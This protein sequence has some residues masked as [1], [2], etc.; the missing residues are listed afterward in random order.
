MKYK[1]F[2]VVFTAILLLSTVVYAAG[3]FDRGDQHIRGNWTFHNDALFVDDTYA[4]F[5]LPLGSFN[6]SGSPIQ[7]DG[8]SAPGMA[9]H[10]S[11]PKIVW[12]TTEV[13]PIQASFW[14]PPLKGKNATLAFR[15]NTSG[16]NATTPGTI[17]WQVWINLDGTAF[18]AAAVAQTAVAVAAS[19]TL[20]DSIELIMNDTAVGQ[21]QNGGWVTVDF[22]NTATGG[23]NMEVSGIQGYY[24]RK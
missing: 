7:M 9:T 10:D 21:L 24:K 3:I 1:K 18:D 20:N 4:P 15:I 11:I 2:A 14:V 13:T 12:A 17:D 16:S 23:G 5:R 6:V 22:W 19:T 8:T